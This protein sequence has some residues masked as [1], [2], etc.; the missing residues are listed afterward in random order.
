MQTTTWVIPSV[1]KNTTRF[2]PSVAKGR[3]HS[4][5]AARA[6]LSNTNNDLSTKKGKKGNERKQELETMSEPEF[7]SPKV[8]QAS[9]V[10]NGSLSFPKPILKRT[11]QG[12]PSA[13]PHSRK[14]RFPS[15]DIEVVIAKQ[16]ARRKTGKYQAQPFGWMAKR[17]RRKARQVD[18]DRL[19]EED[20]TE[21]LWEDMAGERPEDGQSETK[22]A[23]EEAVI[24]TENPFAPQVRMING[25]FVLDTSS[26]FRTSID[27]ESTMEIVDE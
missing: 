13:Q 14:V 20:S 10:G 24:L 1:N 7:D 18:I 3:R 9:N 22:A 11:V 17:P 19:L 6:K 21:E 2:T 16:K 25:R 8:A 23:G 12:Q 26:T 4:A 15:P 27:S 5:P